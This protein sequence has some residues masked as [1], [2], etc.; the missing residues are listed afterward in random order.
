MKPTIGLVSRH[1]IIPISAVQ[2]TAGP[3]TRS[4]ADAA[5]LLSVLAGRDD[6]DAAT[7]KQP[8]ALDTDYTDGL[9]ADGLRGARIGVLRS[10][11][12]ALT[13]TPVGVAPPERLGANRFQVE[14]LPEERSKE[15]LEET[16]LTPLREGGAE[17]ID[18]E[19]WADGEIEAAGWAGGEDELG[20]AYRGTGGLNGTMGYEFRRDIASYLRTRRVANPA[21]G[22]RAFLPTTLEEL[23]DFN[24][25]HA[26]EELDLFGQERWDNALESTLGE[27]EYAENSRRLVHCGGPGGIDKLL[28][29]NGLDALVCPT[30]SAS[31][32][33]SIA[34]CKTHHEL[35]ATGPSF[36]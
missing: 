24:L 17:L 22:E 14:L 34:G 30:A 12:T 2:D 20:A 10:K 27:E 19:L 26:D 3:M 28:Q 5:A 23:R 21:L 33:A 29:E 31:F 1:G 4:V 6:N 25:A 15:L 32:P 18:V 13:A 16:I 8:A 7:A 36:F 35:R 9:S 11:F